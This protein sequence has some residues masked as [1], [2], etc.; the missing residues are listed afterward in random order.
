MRN[1]NVD[2][3][4]LPSK[5]KA[6]DFAGQVFEYLFP[7]VTDVPLEHFRD[8]QKRIIEANLLQLLRPVES[9]LPALVEDIAA[10][11]FVELENVF[12]RLVADARFFVESDPAADC[13]EEVIVAYPGF[14]A[15]SVFRVAHIL[16]DLKVPILP[17]LLTEHAHTQ[18]GIDIHPG[19]TIGVPFFIDHGTGIVVG[20]TTLIGNRVKLYQGVTLGALAVRKEAQG[21]KRHPTIEDNVIIYAG[22]CIL[23][24]DTTVG[25]DSVIG[26]NVW[27]TESVLPYSIVY[28]QT[29]TRI[30]DKSEMRE[31]IDYV[32]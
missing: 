21:Q 26:G 11:F 30:R 6:N 1:V 27:L 13:I 31:V 20:Q 18:T 32:I 2:F 29:D 4:K 17:R 22:S 15:I 9:K 7:S 19:A 8:S 25:N 16:Y 24:G 28:T 14:Y 12:D 3:G 23:G 5:H 10:K